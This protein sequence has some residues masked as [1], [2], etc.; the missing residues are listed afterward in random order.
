MASAADSVLSR[1]QRLRGI[2]YEWKDGEERRGRTGAKR[3]LGVIAQ[4]VEPVFP[5]LVATDP[6][7]LKKVDYL[8]FIA[9]LIEAVK[10]LDERVGELERSASPVSG[11]HSP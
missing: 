2:S 4:E 7:G 8:G 6:E 3:E 11:D 1:L 9:V 5:E 10:E